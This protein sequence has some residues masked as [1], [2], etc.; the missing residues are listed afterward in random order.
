MKLMSADVKGRRPRRRLSAGRCAPSPVFGAEAPA[1]HLWLGRVM[2][3]RRNILVLSR[4]DRKVIV[5]VWEGVALL[6]PGGLR[7]RWMEYARVQLD[8]IEVLMLFY[9]LQVLSWYGIYQLL[10]VLMRE[11]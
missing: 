5:V 3:R 2:T 11:P 1:C 6:D 4:M 7:W 8:L 9:F 10:G